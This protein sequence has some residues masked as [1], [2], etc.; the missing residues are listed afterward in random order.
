MTDDM[1]NKMV[2]VEGNSSSQERIT[3]YFPP[4]RDERKEGEIVA[5]KYIGSH[6]FGKGTPSE[7]TYYKLKDG[8]EIIGV[9]KSSVIA[10]AFNNIE[11]GTYVAIKYLGERMGKTGLKYNDYDIRI[12]KEEA[13]DDGINL[14]EIPF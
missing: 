3:R 6:T 9:R 2:S 13:K 10:S 8:N 4:K 1:F 11:E 5:G 12:S 14:D 7:T